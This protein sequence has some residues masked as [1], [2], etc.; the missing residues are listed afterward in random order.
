M[1]FIPTPLEG[2]FLIEPDLKQDERGFFSRLYCEKEFTAHGLKN[3][4]IQANN[5]LSASKGTLRGLHYQ[6]S[7]MAEVKLVRCVKGAFFDLILDVREDSPTFGQ[8]FGEVLTADNRKMMYVPEGFAHG[9]LTLSDNAEVIYLVSQYYSPDLER[10]IRWNDPMFHIKW[11]E[12]PSI[13]SE[14][15]RSHAL[16]SKSALI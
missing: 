10:G 3:N 11:P 4:F 12:E 9:F 2:A 6:L 7:P 1:R 13:I 15:D 5:S 16:F 8:S 14:R